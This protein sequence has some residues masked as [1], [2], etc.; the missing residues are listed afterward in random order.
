[1]VQHEPL[2]RP[3]F[4]HQAERLR[5]DGSWGPATEPDDIG[6]LYRPVV[7]QISRWDRLKGWAPLLE[8]FALLKKNRG[9]AVGLDDLQRRRLDLVRLVFAG[10]EPASIRDDPEG[11][12]VLAELCQRY[13][14]LD[15]EVQQDVAFISLPMASR[16]E[17]ALMVNALQR[18]STIVVQNSLQEGFGL[19]AAEAMWKKTA[20][21]GS[22]AC[23]LR[24]QIRDDLDGR[25]HPDA[26]DSVE[27]AN[28]IVEML[29]DAPARDRWSRRGQ[30]R[31]HAEFLVFT[32]IR[33]WLSVLTR[34]IG[35]RPGRG[36]R[37][38]IPVPPDPEA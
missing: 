12:E 9:E 13:T 1:M 37:P 22:T 20:V 11:R 32:Q 23:G 14:E 15:P 24:Q 38:S 36:S 5:P 30:S 6:V 29:S 31:V 18:C 4:E 35:H 34:T 10:P 7:T 2:V 26:E 27:L 25:L 19:T 17:N 8:A 28:V 33:K 16:R 21:L 3:A